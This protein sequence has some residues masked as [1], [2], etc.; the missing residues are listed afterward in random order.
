MLFTAF[1]FAS[2]ILG[3]AQ[4]AHASTLPGADIE[5]FPNMT[6]PTGE[7][8]TPEVSS[9]IPFSISSANGF[10]SCNSNQDFTH[11]DPTSSD[12]TVGSTGMGNFINAQNNFDYDNWWACGGST[13]GWI[14][15]GADGGLGTWYY[16]AFYHGAGPNLWQVHTPVSPSA[17]ATDSSTRIVDFT[18]ENNATSTNPVHFSLQ[19]CVS[20]EDIGTYIGVKF[21]LHNIDQNVLLLSAFSPSDIYLL[22]G[23]NATTSGEFN[24]STTTTIGE[25]NYRLNALIERSY[26]GGWFVNPFSPINQD[27]SHQFIV[28]GSG[29]PT[30]VGTFIGGL[31]QNGFN[32]LNDIFASS[33][34]TT[35]AS[36]ANCNFT[37]W[38]TFSLPKCG[39]YLFIPGGDYLN[40]TMKGLKDGV[41]TRIPWGYFTRVVTIFNSTAT[42]S[43]PTFTAHVQVGPGDDSTPPTETLTF[44][45]GDMIAGGGTL[46]NSIS[47]PINGKS[48]KDV[49]EPFVQLSIALA[50]LFTIIADLTGSHRHHT[51]TQEGGKKKLS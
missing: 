18:P 17:C 38:T 1:V 43:L 45:P 49:F 25:G 6:L 33:T 34:A 28:C 16:W 47:D 23:F 3:S 46:L 36:A 14:V 29:D 48:V 7:M 2:L 40:T 42:S 12:W 10:Y 26:L 5:I 21:T 11:F 39:A 51:D 4:T 30:C 27:L 20:A 41:L 44:D 9:R 19:G 15:L 22:D 8:P 31:S 50:V 13:P 37:S 24:F 35:T 32:E